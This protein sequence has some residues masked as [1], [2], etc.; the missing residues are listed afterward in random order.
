MFVSA[1]LIT[2]IRQIYRCSKDLSTH[3]HTNAHSSQ[4]NY[5]VYVGRDET[6]LLQINKAT[7]I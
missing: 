7:V 5:F 6:I 1:L 3:I 4:A 2:L